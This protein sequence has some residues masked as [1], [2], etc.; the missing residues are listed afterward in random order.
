MKKVENLEDNE[1]NK[2]TNKWM[3]KQAF[4]Y[5]FAAFLYSYIIFPT[6]YLDVYTQWLLFDY[7][8]YDW[9]DKNENTHTCIEL[10]L[11]LLLLLSTMML[12]L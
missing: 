8:H 6:K 5:M 9:R 4:T 2:Q 11:L 12:A 7:V 1:T 3:D 10:L